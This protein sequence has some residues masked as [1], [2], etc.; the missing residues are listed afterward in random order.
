[1]LTKFQNFLFLLFFFSKNTKTKS[2]GL[3]NN[4][5][6]KT[7]SSLMST[8]IKVIISSPTRLTRNT[9]CQPHSHIFPCISATTCI[10]TSAYDPSLKIQTTK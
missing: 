9:I 6:T 3:V 4:N 2:C 5:P 1:M 7:Q 10:Q 8:L